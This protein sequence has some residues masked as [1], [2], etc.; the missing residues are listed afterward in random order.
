MFIFMLQMKY[1]S[2]LYVH[3]G[4]GHLWVT[5]GIWKV[6]FPHCMFRV[7]VCCMWIHK[8]IIIIMQSCCTLHIPYNYQHCYNYTSTFDLYSVSWPQYHPPPNSIS[9]VYLPTLIFKQLLSY[10]TFS[11]KL[12]LF[13]FS[14]QWRVSPLYICLMYVHCLQSVEK[15]FVA[16]TVNSCK[17]MLLVFLWG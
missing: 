14:N 4:C 6:V 16:S 12:L 1:I 10:T 8:I 17:E 7:V 13:L 11:F 9:I 2:K 3:L 15:H 5:D